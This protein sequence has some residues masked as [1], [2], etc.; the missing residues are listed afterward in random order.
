MS[1][2]SVDGIE[3]DSTISVDLVDHMGG[4]QRVVAAA[5]ISTQGIETQDAE[6]AGLINFLMRNRHGTPFEHGAMTFR[7][8]AP[9]FVFREWHRHRVGWSYNEESGRYKQLDPKFYIPHLSRF[10]TQV[11]KPGHYRFEALSATTA[12]EAQR[13]MIG[14]CVGAYDKYSI[15]MENGVAREIARMVL[16]VNI[17]SSM[18]ATCNPRSLMHFLGLRTSNDQAKFP[19]M[20]MKEINW[21]ALMMEDHFAR[22]W[23]ITHDAWHKNG[24]VAP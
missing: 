8:Q 23:P 21:A 18:Y 13:S 5:R 24:R 7:I 15:L 22:H 1:E 12:R 20:P 9:I 4:D 16:P 14:N 17:Y 3:F 19:S 11:G 6:A 2:F 10:E